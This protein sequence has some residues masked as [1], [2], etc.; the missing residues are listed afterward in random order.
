MLVTLGTQKVNTTLYQP[1]EGA[2]QI[3]G[4]LPMVIDMIAFCFSRFS[5]DWF[6]SV[7]CKLPFRPSSEQF[8]SKIQLSPCSCSG[9][10]HCSL[11]FFDDVICQ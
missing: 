2:H 5:M 6:H 1:M 7:W 3:D 10:S 8:V 11:W 4:L 9:W